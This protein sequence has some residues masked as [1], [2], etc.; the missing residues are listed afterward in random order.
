LSRLPAEAA[1]P[2]AATPPSPEGAVARTVDDPEAGTAHARA[3]CTQHQGRELIV[4][5]RFWACGGG[6]GGGAAVR[7]VDLGRGGGW[8]L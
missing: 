2:M 8:E 4:N 6:C 7:A 3:G 5:S 1:H